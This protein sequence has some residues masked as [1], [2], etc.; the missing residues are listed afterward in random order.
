MAIIQRPLKQGNT[1]TYQTK[2]TAGY[3]NILATEVDADLDLLYSAWNTG[4]DTVNI[5]DNAIIGSKLAPGVIG[6]RELTDG[7]IATVDLADAAVATAKLAD[8]AVTLPKLAASA[9]TMSG[10]LAGTYPSPTVQTYSG[11][12]LALTSRFTLLTGVS[13]A[14]IQWNVI[15]TRNYDNTK[16]AWL[17]Q[18]NYSSDQFI[19]WRAPAGTGNYVQYLLLDS[20]GTLT[21]PSWAKSRSYSAGMWRSTSQLIGSG[22]TD[23]INFDTVW[24]D[25]AGGDFNQLPSHPWLR[26]PNYPS[27]ALISLHAVVDGNAGLG[28][29]LNIE[30]DNATNGAS[31]YNLASDY[32]TVKATWD[33]VRCMPLTNLCNLR[34]TFTNGS[35]ANRTVSYAIMTL[36]IPG[37][38]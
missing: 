11:S 1:N 12:V 36:T 6:S 2:I 31:W 8:G 13:S 9:K 17:L 38:S 22:I 16:P 20:I 33:V 24:N 15:G 18:S 29:G 7:G 25:S 26:T 35:G 19:V 21:V 10:D 4:V 14:D 5:A 3:T 37:K 23:Y 32:S 28:C 30:Y 34:A 27:W